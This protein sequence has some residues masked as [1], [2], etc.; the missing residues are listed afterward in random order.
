MHISESSSLHFISVFQTLFN[1]L[2]FSLYD[3]NSIFYLYFAS[4]A[5]LKNLTRQLLIA[6]QNRP[7]SSISLDKDKLQLRA[8]NLERRFFCVDFA[9]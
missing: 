7:R 3:G 8:E 1:L 9:K 5:Y 6:S 4:P 2:I